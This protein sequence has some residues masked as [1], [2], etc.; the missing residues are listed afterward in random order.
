MEVII[1]RIDYIVINTGYTSRI[2]KDI[3]QI[4]NNLDVNEIEPLF[5]YDSIW[6]NDRIEH[7]S[8]DRNK[9]DEI[10]DILDNYNISYKNGT[11]VAKCDTLSNA[12]E[13]TDKLMEL[14]YCAFFRY[15]SLYCQQYIEYN[16]K[17]I[18]IFNFD[19]ESG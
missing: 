13:F 18:L 14:N 6:G 1:K 11:I 16:N 7:L 8:H 5:I 12:Y 2:L 4:N 3:D 10:I 19:T 9:I 17:K 15:S